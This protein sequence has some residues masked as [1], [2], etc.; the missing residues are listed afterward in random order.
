MR[1]SVKFRHLGWA[2]AALLL[3][4]G[5]VQL[6]RW[7][8]DRAAEKTHMIEAVEKARAAPPVTLP[9]SVTQAIDAHTD[10]NELPLP[11]RVIADGRFK[12]DQEILLDNQSLDGA[13]GVRVLTLF[14]IGDGPQHVLV[15]RGWLA[16]NPATRRPSQ[17]PRASPAAHVVRGLLT[18]L[19]GVGIRLGEGSIPATTP[20][21]PLLNFLD[22]DALDAAFGPALV[23]GLLRMDADLPDGFERRFSPVSEAMPPE[24]HRGYAVQWFAL[25]ATVIA[26]W[27]LL[28]FRRS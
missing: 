2:V 16:V 24:R 28:A 20:A 10:R 9:G 15:D 5:F 18:A 14:Q 1:E 4:G 27:L 7:Q 12:P 21:R 22:Q 23:P 8:L 17:L 25:A 26:T 6:G 19:P 11:V 13:A 3:A